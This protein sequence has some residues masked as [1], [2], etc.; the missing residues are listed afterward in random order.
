LNRR[1]FVVP[2]LQLVVTRLGDRPDAGRD[3]DRQFWKLLTQ[4]SPA[5]NQ[6]Q[7]HI[8]EIVIAGVH[9]L[10]CV[11]SLQRVSGLEGDIGSFPGLFM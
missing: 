5:A 9:A 11:F 1:C 3:F 6:S 10:A 2:S 4:A 7:Y 8:V